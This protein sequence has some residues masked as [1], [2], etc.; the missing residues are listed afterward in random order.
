M[1]TP[2]V[3]E[4][5]LRRMKPRL[6]KKLYL[7]E[8]QEYAFEL[9]ATFK[10]ALDEQALDDFLDAYID[11]VEARQLCFIGGF[12]PEWLDGTLVA[13]KRYSSPSDEDRKAIADWLQAR[14][15][16]ASVETSEL[17]DAHYG[18]E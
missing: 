12:D 8:F 5:R 18:W 1:S 16:I 4:E 14:A 6:R 13:D 11:V 17:F 9:K 2:N 3:S 15:E 10:N 7:G